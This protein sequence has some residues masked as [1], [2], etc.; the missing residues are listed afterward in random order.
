M[1]SDVGLDDVQFTAY[2]CMLEKNFTLIVSLMHQY[3]LLVL[4][5]SIQFNN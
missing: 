1:G 3:I 2:L 5:F 4:P